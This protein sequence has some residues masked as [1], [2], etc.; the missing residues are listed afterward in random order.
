MSRHVVT[1]EELGGRELAQICAYALDAPRDVLQG[2][3]VALVFEQPSLRTRSSS[4]LAVRSLGGWPMFLTDDEIGLDQRESVEDVGR[5]LAEYYTIC[6]L[7]VRDHG[8]FGRLVE[9]VGDRLGVVNLLSRAAHPTQAVAD[10]LTMAEH[11]TSGRVEDLAGLRVAYVGDV[12]N[13][14]RSLAVALRLLG[15]DVVL[16]APDAYQLGEGG[17]EDPRHIAHGSL[18]LVGSARE[19]VAGAHV[20]YTDSWISMGL[21]AERGERLEALRDFQV[22]EDLLAGADPAAVVM[23]C[24]PAHRGEEV[25]PQVLD[26]PRSLVWRQ[27]A[28]RVSAMRGALRWMKETS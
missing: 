18:R 8:V 7:R 3:G 22:S 25:D 26:T 17:P 15:A 11:F 13:V 5:T 16:G 27:V 2:Q 4:A 10:V 1:L 20:V 23:H 9:T 28:H 6:A 21:E 14:A 12:T 19:A 24:L